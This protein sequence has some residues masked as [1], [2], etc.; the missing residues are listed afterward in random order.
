MGSK[1]ETGHVTNMKLAREIISF[2]VGYGGEYNPSNPLISIA[3]MTAVV[4]DAV[5]LHKAYY[6]D[7]MKKKTAV[8]RRVDMVKGLKDVAKKSLNSFE[9]GDAD[10][11][12]IEDAKGLVRKITGS[13][14]R[15]KRDKNNVPLPNQKSNS[16]MDIAHLMENFA[17][18]LNLYLAS[19][20]YAP[21]EDDLKP[22]SMQ[23]R[24]D[25][26]M[27]ADDEVRNWY[28]KVENLRFTRDYCLYVEGTGLV[29]V[30]LTCKK[31]VRSVYGAR[32]AKAMMVVR[33][34]LRRV[35]N[36]KKE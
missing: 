20:K 12:T 29:D 1:S 9:S 6:N 26:L 4:D 11:E 3:S 2:C 28:A 33:I 25:E 34:K 18:L 5:A 14:V 13:N 31:Y 21:N 8:N 35:M 19:G 27:S 10:E 16:Q 32:S 24:L 22:A 23:A 7:L 30:I 36:I 15:K 17:S